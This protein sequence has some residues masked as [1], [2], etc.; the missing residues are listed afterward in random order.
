MDSLQISRRLLLTVFFHFISFFLFLCCLLF[1]LS[2]NSLLRFRLF[3]CD[4]VIGARRNQIFS[5]LNDD[6]V[7]VQVSVND[8]SLEK[9]Y[10]FRVYAPA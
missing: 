4:L 6:V 2:V 3:F 9:E 8:L 1:V 5:Y 10:H 7:L